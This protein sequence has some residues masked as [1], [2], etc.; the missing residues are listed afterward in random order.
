MITQSVI[1][2]FCRYNLEKDEELRKIQCD[3]P[4][5]SEDNIIFEVGKDTLSVNFLRDR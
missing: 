2:F 4:T 1:S 5:T 3:S